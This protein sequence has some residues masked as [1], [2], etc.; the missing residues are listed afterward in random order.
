MICKYNI[1]KHSNHNSPSCVVFLRQCVN[2]RWQNVTAAP[3]CLCCY[4]LRCGNVWT[5]G[6]CNIDSDR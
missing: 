6:T 2:P 1:Q 4:G 3:V 5:G